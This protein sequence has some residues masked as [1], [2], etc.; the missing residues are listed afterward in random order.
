MP[1]KIAKVDGGYK[2][3][4]DTGK[5]YSEKPLP[6]AGAVRQMRALY[7]RMP[8]AKKDVPAATPTGVNASGRGGLL[9]MMGL[10]GGNLVGGKKKKEEKPDPK[11]GGGVVRS[12]I[13][14]SDFVDPE[15][16]RF[17]IVK[18]GDVSDAVSSFG[19]AQP[20][21]PFVEFKKRVLAICR[22]KGPAFM[23]A[24]PA[25]W[26]KDQ[27]AKEAAAG[28]P[29]GRLVVF[30]DKNG[31]LRW[32]LFSSNAYKDQDGEIVSK[33]ALEDDVE[34]SMKEVGP[35]KEAD[36]GPLRWWH[37]DGADL[38]RCDYRCTSD[39]G[40]TLIESGTFF[41]PDVGE[42]VK[43]KSGRLQ[44]SI[45][46]NH[47]PDE[48][49]RQGVYHTVKVFERSILPQGRAANPFTKVSVKGDEPMVTK[50]EKLKALRALLGEDA[51]EI[52]QQA[53]ASEKELDEKGIAY[54]EADDLD[55]ETDEE[56]ADDGTS[57]YREAD[58]KAG[59]KKRPAPEEDEG[60]P[61]E[62]AQDEE[63]EYMEDDTPVIG[64][65]PVDEFKAMFKEA[66]AEGLRP[67][68]KALAGMGKKGKE[69]EAEEAQAA[70]A[71]AELKAALEA[72]IAELNTA[73]RK[74]TKQLKELQGET[75]RALKG[76]RASEAEDT[77]VDE[78]TQKELGGP[79]QDPFA[80]QFVNE[81]LGI[82]PGQ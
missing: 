69:A 9:G 29:A 76:Y 54:K 70:A 7:A 17:P 10:G 47:P 11:V 78:E 45:G 77:L 32:V 67:V 53:D 46:F 56:T 71:Q 40:R 27:A 34:R 20:P 37:V 48:P 79:A 65:M 36:Y 30:K 19:R 21:I 72:Q 55:E 15:R 68:T 6:R 51:E 74:V 22:R 26:Q 64:N 41:S 13:A 12:K 16:R 4:D 59:K 49:D 2:V 14:A 1:F 25:A 81:L 24:L 73:L 61:E 28:T 23:A 42:I 66:M 31:K 63:E 38:G 62:E 35:G 52:L 33:Q 60:T 8:E 18:P 39:S 57:R 50:E 80:V 5:F 75:P 82:Q 58:E 3:Q 43:K 44:V